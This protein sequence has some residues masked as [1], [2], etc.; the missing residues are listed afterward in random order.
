[1]RQ[2]TAAFAGK[3]RARSKAYRFAIGIIYDVDSIYITSHGDISGVPGT[4]LNSCLRDPIISSQRLKLDEARAEIG[5]MSFAIVDKA[6][7]FTTE[8]R[9]RL[10]DNAGLRGKE[11]RFYVGFAGDSF[12]DMMLVGTQILVDANFHNGAYMIECADIQRALRQDIFEPK[13]TTLASTVTAGDTSIA[14]TDYSEFEMV[15]HGASYTDAP[16]SVVGYFKLKNTIYRYSGKSGGS[17]T[18]CVPVFGTVA[19]TVTIDPAVSS[20][21]REKITEYIYLELPAVKLALAVL[22]GD[23]Y[24]D[25]QS[26]PDHWHMGIAS[27]WVTETDFIGIGND[28]WNPTTDVTPGA[29]YMVRFEGLT[30]IDGKAFLEKEIYLLCGLFSPVYADGSLGLKKMQR[31]G[32]DAAHS[33]VLDNSNSIA[34][35]ELRHAMKSVHNVFRVNWSWNGS[36]FNRATDY[37]DINSFEVHGRADLYERS[38]KGLHGSIHTD[39]AV[40][41]QIDMMRDRYAGPPQEITVRLLDSM[42]PIEIGDVGRG[43]WPHVRDFAGPTPGAG[44]PEIDRAFEVQNISCNYRTGVTVELFGSTARADV[45]PPTQATFSLPD[46]FYDI[47]GTALESAPGITISGGVLTAAS[48]TL[49]GNASATNSGAIFYYLGDLTIASGVTLNIGAN[50]QLRVMGFLQV[51]GA[52]NGIGRGL[53]GVTDAG[54]PLAVTYTI[55][56]YVNDTI[57]AETIPGTPGYVGASRGNDGVWADGD[58]EFKLMATR[59][60]AFTASRHNVAPVLSMQIDGTSLYGLPDDLRGTGGAPGGRAGEDTGNPIAAGFRGG[61]GANGGAGLIIICR[62]MALGANGLID[63]SGADSVLPAIVQLTTTDLYPGTGGSGGPGSL[64][65]LLDGAGLSVPD[66]GTQFR[67]F[68]GAVPIAG[69]P[70][71]NRGLNGWGDNYVGPNPATEPVSGYLDPTLI[72]Q[73]NYSGAALRIQY[74]PASET[75]EGDQDSRPPP[76]TALT[77]TGVVGAIA[78]SASAPPPE[79]WDVIEYY[80]A[81]TNDRSGATLANRSRA[82]T[83]NHG[84]A[85]ATTRYY[86]ARTRLS[87]I[88]SDWYPTSATGGVAGISIDAGSGAPGESIEVEFSTTASGPWHSTFATGD[89]YMRTRVGSGGAWQGPWRVVGEDGGAG[90]PGADGNITSFIF[91]RS[92]TQPA[93]PTGNSPSGWLDSPPSSDGNPLWVSRALKTPAGILV[94]TWSTP[95]ILV[96]D[97]EDGE[98]GVPGIQGPGLF[99][100]ANVVSATVTATSITRSSG[101]GAYTAGA[102]SLQSYSGG[103][104]FTCTAGEINTRKVIGLNDDPAVDTGIANINCGWMLHESGNAYQIVNGVQGAS[105]GTYATGDVFSGV[106]DGDAIRV[107]KNG[108]QL[109]VDVAFTGRLYMDVSLYST[110]ASLQNIHF[111][112]SGLRGGQ[113]DPGDPAQQIRLTSTSQTFAFPATGGSGTPTS[114]TFTATRQNIVLPTT[115]STTP[116]VTL[117]GAGDTRTLSAANFGSNNTVRVRAEAEGFFDEITIIRLTQGAAGANGQ[118]SISGHLT[119]ESHTLVADPD[120]VVS[121]TDLASATGYFLIYEGVVD[122]TALANFEVVSAQS[123]NC[124]VQINTA[125]NTPVS[126]QPRGFYRLVSI[127]GDQARARLQA[128]YNGVTIPVDFSITRARQGQPGDGQN[129]LPIQDWVIGTQ[130]NQGNGG[131]VRWFQNGGTDENFIVLGGAGTAP[132]GPFGTS[133]PLWECRP[134]S[135]GGGD[136]DGGWDTIGIPI[137]HRLSYR[138]TV[139][140]RVNQISGSFYHGCAGGG[141]TYQLDNAVNNNPYFIGSNLPALAPTIQPNKWYLSV[142]IIHGSGYTGGNSGVAGIY[143]PETGRRL[144]GGN[145]FKCA[146]GAATQVHRVYHFYDSNTATRQWMPK[147]RFEEMNG[148]EPTI[149][150]LLGFH[151]DIPW[152]ARGLC[153]AG[154]RTFFK[155]GGVNSWDEGDVISVVGY[156]TCHVQF[157]PAQTDKHFMIGLSDAPGSSF[158]Y[159]NIRHAFHCAAG[160]LLQIYESGVYVGDFGS[161]NLNTKLG[162]VRDAANNVY[163]YKDEAIV[164]GPSPAT[165]PLSYL[166]S[167]FHEP[168]VGALNVAFGPGATFELYGTNELAPGAA[169]QTY[170]VSSPSQTF[171]LPASPNVEI[172][173]ISVPRQ[174]GEYVALVTATFVTYAGQVFPFGPFFYLNYSLNGINS[175]VSWSGTQSIDT[176]APGR[177]ITLRALIPI[178]HEWATGRDIRFR[179]V[180]QGGNSGVQCFCNEAYMQVEIIRR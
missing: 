162:I 160:G 109:G 87:G 32:Q 14:A 50:V 171:N 175:G 141:L 166:D 114:I 60:T 35:G 79:Q 63:L 121:P 74:L 130:G 116:N 49:T 84:F 54:G 20:D 98:P 91:R 140:F 23:L 165:G 12:A 73:R 66:L 178:F 148:S 29:G 82:T 13:V 40:F 129:L 167:A 161:Y 67:A 85:T 46:E 34:V 6:K 174:S 102:H 107:Y 124:V 153:V 21:R 92:A 81:A 147:P 111:G 149:D 173:A 15:F 47:E 52:I 1:M 10:D 62:G 3:L 136:G 26:L 5:T 8:V 24:S 99:D 127:S 48:S 133:E 94:G 118:S 144:F 70:L 157:K 131:T 31:I 134:V 100:W 45:Q 142:G 78:V 88:V 89:L 2:D 77:A 83:F 65:I 164:R 172:L 90:E 159:P 11:C 16:S 59:P 179:T 137:D 51:N 93:T 69:N 43:R 19:E 36:R 64:Y 117:T 168:G 76:I 105:L 56:Q 108:S 128:S 122:R 143:D 155:V 115:W 33:F 28:L 4:V 53:A 158:S 135:G 18:G 68:A 125:D 132:L 96:T 9:E 123:V 150:S 37:I 170:E 61:A 119:N 146:T 106:H 138:S 101:G 154:A 145:E 177:R 139:W 17:F 176:T 151:R 72:S 113:G 27:Q 39:A 112:A 104:F 42:N 71:S 95:T 97:G 126:G 169:T 86:W 7:Q 156:S 30:K 152:K 120:G 75:P 44:A 41:A 58:D 80:A 25:G 103:S 38:F 22:T 57:I 55:D 180:I 163:Y 110:A